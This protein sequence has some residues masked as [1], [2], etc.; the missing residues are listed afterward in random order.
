MRADVAAHAAR[1]LRDDAAML[2]LRFRTSVSTIPPGD[3]V[4]PTAL[5][6]EE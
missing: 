3:T 4:T 2:L 6:D 1:P 5:F